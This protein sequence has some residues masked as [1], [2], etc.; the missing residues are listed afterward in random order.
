MPK[1]KIQDTLMIVKQWLPRRSATLHDLR[2][3]LGKLL[4]I[5]QVCAPAHTFLNRMLATLRACPAQGYID[6]S[7]EFQ[8]D[9]QWFVNFLPNTNGIF[10]IWLG[11]TLYM[12]SVMTIGAVQRFV[13]TLLHPW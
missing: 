8:K 9:P 6:L 2:V 12:S 10:I 7:Q 1:E 11:S 3:L 4:Y 13:T 5:A